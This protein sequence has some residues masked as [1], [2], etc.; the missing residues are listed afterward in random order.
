ML[1]EEI[2]REI[3]SAYPGFGW[4]LR[5]PDFLPWEEPQLVLNGGSVGWT[6]T[7]AR[8]SPAAPA[9]S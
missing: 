7:L 5:A 9:D 8:L 2:D 6:E 4:S 1:Y 3:K